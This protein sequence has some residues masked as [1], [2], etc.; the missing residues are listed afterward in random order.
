MSSSIFF[1]FKSQKEPTRLPFDGT[2]I[3]VFDAKRDIIAIHKL[4]DGTDFDLAIY[5]EE[6]NEEYVDD[7]VMIPRG[8]AITARRLPPAKPGRGTAQRYV[9]GKMPT[10]ALSAGRIE[11]KAHTT[12]ASTVS[13]PAAPS[14]VPGLGSEGQTEEE[15]IAA[16]FQ[17]SSEQWNQ[18]QEQMA[19]AR[20]IHGQGGFKK[21]NTPAPNHPPPTGYVCYRCGEKGHWIQQCPTNADPNFDGRPRVKRTTGIPKSFLK[22]VDKPVITDDDDSKPVSVMVNADGE[23]VVAEPDLASWELYQQK[24]KTA[25]LA[26]EAAAEAKML[27]E[28]GLACPIDNKLFKDAVKTPCCKRTYCDD[29][30]Q[31][32]LVESDLVC[33]SC[34]TKE[35]LLDRLIPDT[36]TREKVK[37][38]LDSKKTAAEEKDTE[39]EKSK[40]P[41]PVTSAAVTSAAKNGVAV[42]TEP[43]IKGE[44][45]TPKLEAMNLVDG[46]V[47][48]LKKRSAEDDGAGMKRSNSTASNDSG[49]KRLKSNPLSPAQQQLLTN[50]G[51]SPAM[52]S[53]G[54]ATGGG[55]NVPSNG[56][57]FPQNGFNNNNSNNMN[58][59]DFN[60][61]GNMMNTGGIDFNGGGMS[62]M[63][64]N[65]NM[66]GMGMGMNNMGMNNMG[67]NNNMNMNNMG[68]NNMGMN[69]NMN[70]NNMNNMNGMGMGMGMMNMGAGGGYNN[71]GNHGNM[72]PY[73]NM[74]NGGGYGHMNNGMMN[75]NGYYN[76]GNNG[77]NNQQS[78]FNNQNQWGMQQQQH[79]QQQ[80]Q[81]NMGMMSAG[82]GNQNMGMGMGM[83]MGMNST[84]NNMNHNMNMNMGGAP[85]MAN[86][87]QGWNNQNNGNDSD[88]G[89]QAR[90]IFSE[91]FPT[92]EDSPY[93]RKPVNPY[94]HL[95]PKRVR[96]SDYTAVGGGVTD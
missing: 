56:V 13:K 33:P 12:H 63:N 1:K 85:A 42:K 29:C 21:K 53:I 92:D 18:T 88:G 14:P 23:Y 51:N 77:Y 44:S 58:G 4:G 61:M 47:A 65:M 40:S 49:S 84:N 76:Q 43:G 48:N 20:P 38:Y 7:T 2:V 27:E 31:N 87:N 93:M 22:T 64:M 37:G 5:D 46:A 11:K 30:I 86:Q 57:G 75:H 45:G 71:G 96:P 10:V 74:N 62:N 39:K 52:Q 25:G 19:N 17:A 79:Q 68:Y 50:T 66:N 41:A 34:D 69:N 89:L 94:R 24:T 72:M 73:G 82:V 81:R 6:T 54:L 90:K 67:M 28:Q 36:E 70:M 83:G 9:T 35:V 91:P 55:Q 32:A 60:T 3:S 16:M 78:Q 80:Q 95:R 8:T 15:R 26:G 59:F